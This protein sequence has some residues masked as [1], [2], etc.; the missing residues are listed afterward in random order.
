M[1]DEKESGHLCDI[2]QIRKA[3]GVQF[4]KLTS[5]GAKESTE[6]SK[7]T[8]L[9]SPSATANKRMN[10][11]LFANDI[12]ARTKFAQRFLFEFWHS[13][14]NQNDNSWIYR[15]SEVEF[16]LLLGFEDRN[17]RVCSSS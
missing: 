2:S 17:M 14:D 8:Y 7:E 10:L 6:Q 4:R 15:G 1:I 9:G 12:S 3:A 16:F 13:H 5:N 11:S